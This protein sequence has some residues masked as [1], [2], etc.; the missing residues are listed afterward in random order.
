MLPLVAKEVTVVEELCRKLETP[1]VTKVVT[2]PRIYNNKVC[3]IVG[4]AENGQFYCGRPTEDRD[5]HVK[6]KKGRKVRRITNARL[7]AKN[8]R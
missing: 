3:F 7:P 8:R 1:V 4:T 5:K 6:R 2:L